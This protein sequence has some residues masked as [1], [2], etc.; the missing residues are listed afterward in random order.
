MILRS[1]ASTVLVPWKYY[2]IVSYCTSFLT[3]VFNDRV[4]KRHKSG[5]LFF[6]TEPIIKHLPV[7][8]LW[9]QSNSF[10][11][12]PQK[13][14][15]NGLFKR[16]FSLQPG[17]GWVFLLGILKLGV[18]KGGNTMEGGWSRG[19]LFSSTKHTPLQVGS[20]RSWHFVPLKPK[21]LMARENFS[22]AWNN[23]K[24]WPFINSLKT[25]SCVW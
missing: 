9:L 1:F 2:V 24:L 12:S 18:S 5:L 8:A 21:E 3:S 6:L 13:Y 23:F 19:W 14:A 20:T 11:P 10:S 4:G 15:H 17:E 22:G 16:R 7:S 25:R